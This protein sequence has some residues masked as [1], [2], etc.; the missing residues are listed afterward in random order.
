MGGRDNITY[1]RLEGRGER[2][3]VEGLARSAPAVPLI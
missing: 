3:Y 2:E 1:E